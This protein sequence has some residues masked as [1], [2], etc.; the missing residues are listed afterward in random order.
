MRTILQFFVGLLFVVSLTTSTSLFAQTNQY[1]HFDKVDDYVTLPN[2]SQYIANSSAISMAGWFFT[3]ANGYGQGMMSFRTSGQGFYLIELGSGTLECRFQNSSGTL[4]EVVGPANT[5]V[6]GLWQHYAWV[7]NGSSVTL[8]VNGN[9]IGS[10]PASGQITFTNIEFTIGKCLLGGF[11]FIFGGRADEVSVWNKALTQA[12]IQDMMANELLGTETG[13]QMYYKFNQGNP[14]GNNT[15]I[16]KLVSEVGAGARDADLLNFALTGNT[17]NF[18]GTLITGY[19]AISFSQIPDKLIT[20][21]PFELDA[22]ATSGLPV[23]LEIVSG[24]AT[25]SGDTVT[26]TGLAGEVTIKASQPGDATYNPAVDVVNSFMVLDPATYVPE[27][28]ARS[29]LEGD[30][31][32]PTL[33]AIQLATIVDIGYP[34]L[35]SVG[36]VSF[37][38]DGTNIPATNWGGGFYTGWWTPPAY[39]SYSLIIN[40]DNN[41]GSTGTKSLSINI[42]QAVTNMNVTAVQDVWLE[43]NT[44]TVTVDA[45]LPS[46]L[47][48]FNQIIATLN[49]HC[50][51]GGCGEWDRVASIDARGHNGKWIE[52]IR[53]I[54]PYGTACD[55]TIDLTDYMSILQGK[56]AFRLNCGTLDN[57]YL[58][59]LSFA[60]TA[61]TPAHN[62]SNVEV[63][64][65]DTYPFGDYANLQPVPLVNKVFPNSIVAAKL[66]I[67][68]TGHGWGDL[69]TSNAAEFYEATHTLKFNGNPVSQHL[70][71][72]CNPNPD[73]CQPQAGTWYHN[74]AGWCPGA[75]SMV[76]DY[77]LSAYIAMG[78]VNM[79]YK[80]FDGYVDYCHPNHPDCMDNVTCANCNDGFNPHYIIT[81]NYI[82]F[83]D[84]YFDP[85][86]ISEPLVSN[87]DINAYP[88]PSAGEFV[89]SSHGDF[90]NA[91][92]EIFD[93]PGRKIMSFSWDG[94]ERVVNLKSAGMGV[95]SI[96]ITTNDEKITKRVV[97]Q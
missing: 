93:L 21:G 97:I 45:E 2:G 22:I 19:Q 87:I 11:N 3:E 1:L 5:V 84:S 96:V 4:A 52:I 73:G 57:G 14:G 20:D 24:P 48:A 17:S 61:G 50:P 85:I 26:L 47:G 35:F 32:V 83:Y 40:A 7:Y 82:T 92:V 71:D 44:P 88:N 80:F 77:D 56:I 27:I 8:F 38:I 16:T 95:Y 75:I 37:T 79:E 54:T 39:G 68:N 10:T 89:L 13:L 15:S 36:D 66:K 30:V 72:I 46:Y 64:W 91:S 65:Q 6:P 76:F 94:N 70:W 53:Y 74:R 51:T 31:Y 81:A 62:Y 41:Y 29:P 69:N 67:M 63:I 86:E 58:Y 90:N 9:I 78:T 59:D 34:G 42:V 28:D 18:L 12:E 49:V 25:I 60:Y 23:T 55:H 43:T 33:T